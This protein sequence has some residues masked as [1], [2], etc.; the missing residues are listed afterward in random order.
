VA[1]PNANEH[2]GPAAFRSRVMHGLGQPTSPLL[3]DAVKRY[4]EGLLR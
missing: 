4:A 3:K 2:K 1:I